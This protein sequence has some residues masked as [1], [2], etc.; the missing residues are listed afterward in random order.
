MKASSFLL[1][2]SV[3]VMEFLLAMQTCFVYC[4]FYF[5]FFLFLQLQTMPVST[6]CKSLSQVF[7]TEENK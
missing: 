7:R 5:I 2:R 1:Y 6:R 3:N 4:Q